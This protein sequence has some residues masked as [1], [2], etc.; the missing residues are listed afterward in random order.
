MALSADIKHDSQAV[1]GARHL[2]MALAYAVRPSRLLHPFGF[3]RLLIERLFRRVPRTQFLREPEEALAAPDGLVDIGGPMT[4]E[5]L[6]AA[7]RRAIFP[8]CHAGPVKW[9]APS[10]RAVLFLEESR[11]EKN[12]RRLLR[13]GKYRVTFDTAFREVMRGCAEPRAGRYALTWISPRFMEAYAKLH[14]MGHAHSV[15]VWDD[16]EGV[17]AGGLYGVACGGVFFTESQFAGKRDTSKIAFV[18]LNRHL[19]H[20]G[21]RLNDGKDMTGH[22]AALGMREIPRAEFDRIVREHEN[23]RHPPGPWEVDPE[24]DVAGWKPEAEV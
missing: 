12:L 20:W 17:L 4:P 9:W 18:T 2:A 23:D 14:E 16:D 15:E 5:R 10:R 11:I 24:L 6:M 1:N 22:L 19:Q 8:W 13:Q 21:Y 3:A 7:Y